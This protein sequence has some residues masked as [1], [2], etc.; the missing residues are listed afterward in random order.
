MR[1]KQKHVWLWLR[2]LANS[3]AYKFI[4]SLLHPIYG[5]CTIAGFF[6]ILSITYPSV[7]KNLTFWANQPQLPLIKCKFTK[8]PMPD[9][10]ESKRLKDLKP[11]SIEVEF[12]DTP[13][14]EGNVVFYYNNN[15]L[16]LGA[17]EADLRKTNGKINY[18]VTP[19]KLNEAVKL[20]GLY[21]GFPELD[22]A[23]SCYFKAFILKE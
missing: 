18:F 4:T 6:Y 20:F 13:S 5:I 14:R 1:K 15:H 23:T 21:H 11:Y 22:N 3:S 17:T 9:L 16:V 2:E 7:Y 19:Y 10:K 12:I 8:L